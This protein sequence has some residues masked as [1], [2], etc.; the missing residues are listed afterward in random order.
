MRERIIK[1]KNCP[2][3]GNHYLEEKKISKTIYTFL[4]VLI[5]VIYNT[6][7]YRHKKDLDNL[8]I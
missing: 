1:S 2:R 5:S 4:A 6:Y 7:Y 3:S 8:T